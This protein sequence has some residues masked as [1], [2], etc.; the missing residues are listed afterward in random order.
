MSP[1]RDIVVVGGGPA[2]LAAGAILARDGRT[3]TVFERGDPRAFRVGETLGAEVG[4]RLRELGAWP[5]MAPVLGEQAPFVTVSSAWGSDD[6][7]ERSTMF[8]PL[9]AGWHVDRSRFDR[10]LL[11]WSLEA[12]ADVRARCGTCAV[13]REGGGFLVTPRRGDAVWGH[14]LVDA[15]GRGSPATRGLSGRRW[16]AHDRQVAILRVLRPTAGVDPGPGLTL[17]AVREGF[18][19][20]S[21]LANGDF[22]AVLITDADVLVSLGRTHDERFRHALARTRH[23]A[24]RTEGFAPVGP[25]RTYRADSGRL[26]PDRGD[27]WCALGDAA[28]ATDPLGGNGVARAL[29]SASTALAAL[30]EPFDPARAEQRFSDYLDQRAE[31]YWIESRWPDAPFWARRRPVDLDGRPLD[32][33]RVALS[34]SPASVLRWRQEPPCAAE[35]WLPRDALSALRDATRAPTSAHVALRAVSEVAP[36]GAR[37]LVVGV[38]WLLAQGTL[39][40]QE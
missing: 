28:M 13:T 15:S 18:W 36:L 25:A 33:K 20:S 35:A 10:A 17:E 37:R 3:V 30:H 34:L 27:G 22:L 9:G 6:L 24:R 12:G 23:T 2:G 5:L 32:W 38:Q 29:K 11:E 39:A 21:Q 7:E 19:Y 1:R 14:R 8:H 31:F 4:A 40:E 26:I 16:L